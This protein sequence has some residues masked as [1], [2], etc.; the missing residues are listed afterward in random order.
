MNAIAILD[1]IAILSVSVTIRARGRN[2]LYGI[3]ISPSNCT[4]RAIFISIAD[5]ERRDSRAPVT[6]NYRAATNISWTSS[7][8]DARI[9]A[10]SVCERIGR[11]KKTF[12]QNRN[13]SPRTRAQTLSINLTENNITGSAAVNCTNIARIPPSRRVNFSSINI[14]VSVE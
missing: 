6:D 1:E 2:R 14:A 4:S 8:R 9:N 13:I 3:T 7:S 5:N 12:G 11:S 10:V